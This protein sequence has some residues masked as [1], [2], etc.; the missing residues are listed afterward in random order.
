MKKEKGAL[1]LSKLGKLSQQLKTLS[2]QVAVLV[3]YA[4][5]V[6]RATRVDNQ[7]TMAARG[8][9]AGAPNPRE[10]L[11]AMSDDRHKEFWMQTEHR[12]NECSLA[13]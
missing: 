8:E 7:E 6:A 10:T 1:L 3:H 11:F 9:M 2:L 4:T 13:E 5:R 12:M